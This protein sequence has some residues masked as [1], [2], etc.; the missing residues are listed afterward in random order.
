MK[1]SIPIDSVKVGMYVCDLDLKWWQ[2]DFLLHQFLVKSQDDIEK[3]RSAG[4]HVVVVDLSR[5]EG[6]TVTSSGEIS[7]K[8]RFL[9]KADE[10]PR[11][12]LPSLE[13]LS[14]PSSHDLKNFK[15][16]KERTEILLQEGF[17]DVRFGKEI[18][19]APFKEKIETMLELISRNPSLVTFLMEIE[20]SDD[21]IYR[22][23]V[24]TMILSLGLAIRKEIP[25]GDWKAW[26]LAAL[27]HDIGKTGIPLPVLKKTGPLN[28]SE[29]KIIHEHPEIGYRLLKNHSD[30]DVSGLCATVAVEHHER[31][32]GAGY[33]RGTALDK[34]SPVTRSLIALDMYEALTA[35][36]V[37]RMGYSPAKTLEILLKAAEEKI[38]P[39][40]VADL[41]KMVGIYPTGSLIETIRG[42]IVLVGGYTD[43]TR[44]FSGEVVIYVLKDFNGE[45][46]L[47]PVRRVKSGLGP[48]EV[49]RTLHPREIGLSEKEI[50]RLIYPVSRDR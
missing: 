20:E 8:E 6:S 33:P 45:W 40:S 19:V 31:K 3:L 35:N 28:Q 29:W 42:E 15:E 7:E 48:K 10:A 46:L 27:F 12:S 9:K 1:K 26:G 36:R 2:T 44:T 22:H 47:R 34:L 5:S 14:L 43:P 32:N 13:L 50:M 21:E 49:K 11:S 17:K 41:V 37:Y 30:K 24:N 25:T 23:S 18:D 38:D 4:V 16:L 39:S